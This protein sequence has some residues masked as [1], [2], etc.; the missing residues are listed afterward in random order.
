MNAATRSAMNRLAAQRFPAERQLHD[1]AP[2]AAAA[3]A[4][5]ERP[6]TRRPRLRGRALAGIGILAAA[7]VTAAVVF[8]FAAVL[9]HHS[10]PNNP[11]AAAP[12]PPI[13]TSIAVTPT[14]PTSPQLLAVTLTDLLPRPG[15]ITSR[16]GIARSGLVAANLVYND[17]H[18]AAQISLSLGAGVGTF[19]TQNPRP[20]SCQ[21]LPDGT[22]LFVYQGSEYPARP[23]NPGATK[24][25]VTATRGD[26][27]S[28]EISEWN[29]PTEKGTQ[30][31]RPEPPL[32]IPELTSIARN[33]RISA[34][35]DPAAVAAASSLFTPS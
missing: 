14:V 26:G 4:L 9:P 20:T 19:C 30:A 16:A 18:G 11:A 27:I 7:G 29:A 28:V 35:A 24:W 1:T 15:T 13:Q 25:S 32:T 5:T 2:N 17:G 33:P 31:S 12:P 23:Q 22:V 10:A 21:I 3:T 6:T 34:T 8:G